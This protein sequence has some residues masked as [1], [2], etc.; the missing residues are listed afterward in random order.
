M[1]SGV[2]RNDAGGAAVP[3]CPK[4]WRPGW[5]R[6][7][8]RIEAPVYCPSWI[9]PPLTG[10]IGGQWNN[11]RSVD[12]RDRSYL[13]GFTWYEVG[14]GEVHVNFRGYPETAKIPR[15][16][17]DSAGQSVPCFAD[18]SGR[19]RIAGR[20]VTVYTA[21]Q[22]ADKW[23]IVYAWTRDGALYVLSEHVATPYGYGQVA[24]YLD[25]MMR[26]L[27]LIKPS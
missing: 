13:V 6:L 20:N 19:K 16:P 17:G 4:K 18:A 15:C 5:Q 26:G 14:S 9:T 8:N 1:D 23:H 21:N 22:G 12:P 25:R 2:G 10:E 27:V 11:I 3:G 7:A 24:G